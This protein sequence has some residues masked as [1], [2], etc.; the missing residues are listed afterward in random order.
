MIKVKGLSKPFGKVQPLE[1]VDPDADTGQIR[2]G[3]HGEGPEPMYDF[4]L[5]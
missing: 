3:P 5:E 2:F 1:E 4:L